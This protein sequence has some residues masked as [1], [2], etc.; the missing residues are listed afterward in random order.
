MEKAFKKTTGLSI[1]EGIEKAI[2][3]GWKRGVEASKD[4]FS[5][6]IYNGGISYSTDPHQYID[7]E[8]MLLDPSWWK[9]LGKAEGWEESLVIDS[10]MRGWRKKQIE[11]VMSLQMD[12][13]PL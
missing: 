8:E 2:E 4:I 6:E 12:D 1:Q 11:F 5:F 7:N 3:G 10:V 9:S 13:T